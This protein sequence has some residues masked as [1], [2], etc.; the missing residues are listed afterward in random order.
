[1]LAHTNIYT[2]IFV[3]IFLAIILFCIL[4]HPYILYRFS[5]IFCHKFVPFLVYATRPPA[6]IYTYTVI[7]LYRPLRTVE[8]KY[9]VCV[10][11]PDSHLSIDFIFYSRYNLYLGKYMCTWFCT[12][13]RFCVDLCVCV[14]GLVFL[15]RKMYL[16]IHPKAIRIIPLEINVSTLSLTNYKFLQ[17]SLRLAYLGP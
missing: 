13:V 1:M 9:I 3:Y 5:F 8:Y 7:H 15:F 6:R 10:S 11:T 16:S 2:H 17:S 14:C 12:S 4:S